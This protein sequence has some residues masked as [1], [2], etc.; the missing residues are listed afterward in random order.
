MV[1]LK[2]KSTTCNTKFYFHTMDDCEK[3]LY[4][5]NDHWCNVPWERPVT[6]SDSTELSEYEKSAINENPKLR[7]ERNL[8]W[9][10]NLARELNTDAPNEQQRQF[11]NNIIEKLF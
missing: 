3:F 2:V 8:S 6:V 10:W 9:G 5:F 11:L 1:E 4:V 7:A